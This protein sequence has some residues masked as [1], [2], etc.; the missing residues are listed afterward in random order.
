MALSF[1]SIS[2]F[3]LGSASGKLTENF[4]KTADE[5]GKVLYRDGSNVMQG[6]L[7]LNSNYIINAAAATADNQVP[8]F[9][10][11]KAIASTILKGDK[12]DPGNANSTPIASDLLSPSTSIAASTTLAA[13][14]VSNTSTAVGATLSPNGVPISADL[15]TG[16]AQ[17]KADLDKKWRDPVNKR[18]WGNVGNYK[19]DPVA[20]NNRPS[21]W[22]MA[23]L[24][25]NYYWMAKN[26]GIYAADALSLVRDNFA[27]LL[28]RQGQATLSSPTAANDIG[29]VDD[30][31]FIIEYALQ[32]HDLTGNTTA[33]QIGR[34]LWSAM[35]TTWADPNNSGAGLL[36]TTDAAAAT[37]GHKRLS[38]LFDLQGAQS[39]LYL[40]AHGG[41][42]A[43]LD[44]ATKT[45]AW[46]KQRMKHPTF[47][48]LYMEINVDPTSATYLQ[49]AKG[50]P[51]TSILPHYSNVSLWGSLLYCTVAKQLYDRAPNAQYLADVNT[52]LE[53]VL[54]P[55][56]FLKPGNVFTAIR[57]GWTEGTAFPRF[58]AEVLTGPFAALLD[59]KLIAAMRKAIVATALSICSLRTGDYYFNATGATYLGGYYSADWNGPEIGSNGMTSWMQ[60]ANVDNGLIA[61]PEQIQTT[62]STACVV[63]AASLIPDV[64]YTQLVT[65]P[66]LNRKMQKFYESAILSLGNQSIRGWLS[67]DTL[68]FN[69]GRPGLEPSLGKN[70]DGDPTLGFDTN[71]YFHF[72]PSQDTYRFNIAGNVATTI[73][74][75]GLNAPAIGS[76]TGAVLVGTSRDLKFSAQA[77]GNNCIF[78]FDD[79]DQYGYARVGDSHYFNVGNVTRTS[80]SAI[81]LVASAVQSNGTIRFGSDNQ[82]DLAEPGARARNIYAGNGTIQTSDARTKQ[83][84]GLPPE[85]LLAAIRS[86]D[87][88]QYQF[89]D[90][91][92]EKGADHARIHTGII[93]QDLISACEAQGVDWRRYG[94]I[95]EDAVMEDRPVFADVLEPVTEEYQ[96]DHPDLDL[97][98][99]GNTV[100]RLVA[101]TLKRNVVEQVP[102]F[103][104]NGAPVMLPAEDAAYEDRPVETTKGTIMV[105]TLVREALP[106]RQ[107]TVEAAKL[108]KVRRQTGTTKVQRMEADGVTP[109]TR[110]SVRYDQLAM[111]MLAAGR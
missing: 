70:G 18:I 4:N 51:D 25:Q 85:P 26:G 55:G 9:G 36:Y 101:R 37:L 41:T 19:R 54:R 93:A 43:H 31:E 108:Q 62:G 13:K 109:M 29:A 14:I 24:H 16:Y 64:G 76:T 6:A 28:A 96:E 22:C 52:M 72:T 20:I 88:T 2:N 86:I 45:Y 69:K 42:Q 63:T 90:A 34:D 91:V 46:I 103:D 104:V 95:G 89:L 10:Q 48:V 59:Q 33:L 98:D 8:N 57:D 21:Q 68:Y 105:S 74:S 50:S 80:I 97:D 107:K 65:W 83:V 79:G 82:F 100:V 56:T 15:A 27:E 75:G 53:A 1:A 110:L 12:G 58:V 73:N 40:H 87:I 5:F 11:V 23:N 66:D 106:E 30:A 71:D 32:V 38:S 44:F 102:V 35:V 61:L 84:V 3:F 99:D 49:P 94:V 81:G 78:N 39:A 17:L 7:D 47:G 67:V 60:N 111:L 92:A 77:S